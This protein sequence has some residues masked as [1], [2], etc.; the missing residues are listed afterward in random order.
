MTDTA[1]LF[2]ALDLDAAAARRESSF[3]GGIPIKLGGETFTLP[4][5]LPAEA[6]DPLL[7]LDVDMASIVASAARVQ[8]TGDT[9]EAKDVGGQILI[10][11]LLSN[12]NLPVDVI[13]GVYASLAVL[14]GEEQWAL[15]LTKKPSI[16]TY[17]V[18]LRGLWRAY[19]V[20]LGEAFASAAPSASD[21]E[22]SSPTS[23]G[24]TGSTRA[25]STKAPAKKASSVSAA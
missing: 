5:E 14:F 23:K 11:A 1:D 21:G 10:E 18:L 20:S 9:D 2:E 19:G 13:R 15:W 16:P 24:S 7:D 12:P 3:P 25:A 6:L 4:A 8:A 22:T 17:A